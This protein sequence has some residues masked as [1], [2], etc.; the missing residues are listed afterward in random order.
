MRCCDVTTPAPRTPSAAATRSAAA[1]RRLDDA[2]RSYL[3]EGGAKP[4]PLA[5][6]TSLV[7]GA[8]ALRLTADAVLDLWQRDEHQAQGD[9]AAASTQLQATSRQITGW[10]DG[11]SASLAHDVAVPSP[12]AQDEDAEAHFVE[13]VR[14][15][16]VDADGN[17]N[18]TAVRMIWTG[19]HLDA[20][21]RMQAVLA[22]PARAASD[23][24]SSSLLAGL[25]P[26]H[27]DHAVR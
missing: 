18:A 1:S 5:D 20:V 17:A 9:R 13:A 7:T 11:L 23:Q 25:R 4:V 26:W 24:R 22:D 27:I 15:D 19:D 6:V 2:F 12:L 3:A 21:R 8:A 14:H 16:L 10:Y